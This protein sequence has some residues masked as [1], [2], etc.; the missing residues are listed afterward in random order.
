MKEGRR[1]EGIIREEGG[2][3][4]RRK[5]VKRKK[6]KKRVHSKQESWQD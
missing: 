6:R 4:K 3:E 1:K 2:V 5:R